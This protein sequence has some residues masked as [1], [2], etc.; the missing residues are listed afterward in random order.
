MKMEV[1][2]DLQVIAGSN[3]IYLLTI[4]GVSPIFGHL[5]V[6]EGQQIVVAHGWARG[7]KFVYFG[8]TRI[9]R[10][11]PDT[12][13]IVDHMFALA[14][15]ARHVYDGANVKD[16]ADPNTFFEERKRKLAEFEERLKSQ[17]KRPPTPFDSPTG[18][19]SKAKQ[20]FGRAGFA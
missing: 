6:Q 13:Q 12:I 11:D 2:G 19:P 15:D 3:T 18:G 14:K 10:A 5:P 8:P 17:R 20:W 4:E 1:C 16:D 7:S 9:D